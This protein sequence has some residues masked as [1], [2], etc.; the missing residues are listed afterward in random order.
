MGGEGE[1]WR[2]SVRMDLFPRLF[3]SL[4]VLLM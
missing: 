2:K 1:R 4:I 3:G